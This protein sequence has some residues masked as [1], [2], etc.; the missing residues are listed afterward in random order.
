MMSGCN[1]W[2]PC[3]AVWRALA[4]LALLLATAS[5]WAGVNLPQPPL[6]EGVGE[7]VAPTEEM[8]RDHMNL[9]K[10]QRNDTVRQGIRTERFSLAGCVGCHASKDADGDYVAVNAP[11]QFCAECH[12]YTAVKIDCF[13][14][15]ATRPDQP[16]TAALGLLP[17]TALPAA[18]PR[19]VGT[20]LAACDTGINVELRQ[21][22]DSA[23]DFGVG[24]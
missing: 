15:H 24:K 9:L 19:L 13:Q 12:A 4:V 8:R 5:A 16:E 18:H 17:G 11:G 23:A 2:R 6:P 1:G 22:L 7:C 14:C 3:G 20:T 10:H 21:L